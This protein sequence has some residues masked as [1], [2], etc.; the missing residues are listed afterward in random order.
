MSLSLIPF[1]HLDKQELWMTILDLDL[2][3]DLPHII[4]ITA[5]GCSGQ[6]YLAVL[7]EIRVSVLFPELVS[8]QQIINRRSLC[9][10]LGK[11][12]QTRRLG[13][14]RDSHIQG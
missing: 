8:Q 13:A 14:D 10:R 1:R 3:T 7:G 12:G 2:M 6:I 5:S 4:L 11:T 9:L